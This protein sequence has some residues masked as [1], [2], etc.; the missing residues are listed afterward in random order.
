MEIKKFMDLYKENSPQDFFEWLAKDKVLEIRFLNDYAGNKFNNWEL[1]K[2]LAMEL[3]VPYRFSSLYI[4]SFETLRKI[5]LYKY[6]N[7]TLTRYYNIFVSVN[8]R[9]QV[10]VLS[11]KGI[12]YK[13][14]Y[15]G[16]AG[17]SHIQT[18]LCD[19]EH[20]GERK[21]SATEAMLEECIQGAKYLIKILELTDYYLNISGN[22]VHL[23]IAMNPAI[24]LPIP[25]FR[26]I[27]KKIKYNL[28]EEPIHKFIKTY[29]NYIEKLNKQLKKYNPNLKV[30]EGAKDIARIA[31]PVGSWNIKKNKTQRAVGTVLKSNILNKDINIK[32]NSAAPLISRANKEYSRIKAESST[33]RYNA[34]NLWTCPLYKLLTLRLLPSTLSRNHYLEQSFARILRDNDIS[35]FDIQELI[36]KMDIAQQKTVQV[37]PDYLDD[38]LSFNPETI[39]AYCYTCKL[40]LVYPVMGDIYDITEDYITR[41]HYENLNS[42]SMETVKSLSVETDL[43]DKYTYFELKMLIRN[44]VDKYSRSET[45]FTL[46]TLL[47][48]N[49]DYLHRN[50]IIL[51]ILNKTRR[52]EK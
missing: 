47:I 14:Y 2:K 38:G 34:L 22:G 48:D 21:D 4:D 19:I 35:L 23:W 41:D 42:Y 52:Q 12:M 3:E 25:T 10:N 51:K 29:N 24:Y 45:L 16:I 37:D 9:R 46:K 32:F 50:L 20:I 28:K 11:S 49:W 33:H 27:N 40:D 44:L 31:R 26:E 39:N 18:I 8:P 30:D 7:K 36:E 6:Q 15:G 17:T 13:S 5:L 1:I 43:K